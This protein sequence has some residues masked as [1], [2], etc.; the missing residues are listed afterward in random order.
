LG[1]SLKAQ[2]A[3]YSPVSDP[4]KFKTDFS[5]ATQ[6]IVSIKS[7]FV[8]EKNLSMLSERSYQKENFGLKGKAWCEWN[9]IS[10]TNT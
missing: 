10:L 6:K 3:G 7:D 5:A 1:I 9:T 8:Q 4:A 2:Y